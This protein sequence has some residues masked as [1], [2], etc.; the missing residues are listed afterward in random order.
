MSR[1]KIVPYIGDIG[2]IQLQNYLCM[3]LT[4]ENK[5]RKNAQMHSK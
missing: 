1:S 3:F 4:I 2:D 5:M